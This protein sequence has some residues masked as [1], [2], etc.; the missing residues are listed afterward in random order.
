MGSLGSPENCF[1]LYTHCVEEPHK[2]MYIDN[3]FNV[4]K[5]FSEHVWSKYTEDGRYNT[6]FLGG[7][8][9]GMGD[10]KDMRVDDPTKKSQS[11]I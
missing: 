10:I 9:D 6:D 11:N 8:V 2:F 7:A 1:N 5:C 4:H 3:D